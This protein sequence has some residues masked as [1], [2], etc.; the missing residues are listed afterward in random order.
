MSGFADDAVDSLR[1]GKVLNVVLFSD[2]DVKAATSDGF[3]E[4][5]EYKL[6]AAAE[7]GEIFTPY[8]PRRHREEASRLIVV[9]EGRLDELMLTSFAK[10][11]EAGL[12]SVRPLT[13]L[14]TLGRDGLLSVAEAVAH[15]SSADILV[16]ADAGDTFYYDG[17][18]LS[19][20]VINGKVKILV[21]TGGVTRW[22][23]EG[24][25]RRAGSWSPEEIVEAVRRVDVHEL[26]M[27][28]KAFAV[29]AENLGVR[30]KGRP[31]RRGVDETGA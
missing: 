7:E 24:N 17:G 16:V 31:P 23:P 26:A 12:A 28:D 3:A 1:V 6:R 20:D 30:F 5:M 4:V 2:G 9:V 22:L 19:G 14:T 25:D 10:R 27:R 21:V 29:F 11:L 15:S 18:R 13:V 8:A